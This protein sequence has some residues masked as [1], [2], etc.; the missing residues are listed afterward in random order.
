MV[1]AVTGKQSM[2]SGVVGYLSHPVW[3]P[4]GRG[5]LALLRDKETNF[6]RNRI[7]DIP[8]PS[9]VLRALTH[10]IDGYSSLSLSADGKTLTTILG[11]DHFYLF[12]T[13]AAA[14]GSGQAEQ[15]T[16]HGQ[17]FG[18]SWMPDGQMII[19]QDYVLNL[20]N[21]ESR[22]KTPLTAVQQD[23][24]AFQPSAC[25]DGRYVV[26]THAG[27][28]AEATFDHLA[29]ERG[30]QQP[31]AAERRKTGSVGFVLAR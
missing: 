4:D 12:G 28:T 29:H 1:D 22:S 23:V 8:Y 13:P 14:V 31:E 10:D 2:V 18:F 16:A 9:G 6:I 25:A 7:V 30:W 15:L 3:L 20:F 21:P 19:T 5:V 17:Y 26:F 24:L 11:E 27:Q